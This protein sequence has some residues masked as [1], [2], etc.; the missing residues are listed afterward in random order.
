[1]YVLLYLRN[2]KKG[3]AGADARKSIEQQIIYHSWKQERIAG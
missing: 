2:S 1:M 3:C